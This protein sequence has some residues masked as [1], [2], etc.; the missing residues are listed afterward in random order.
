MS[1]FIYN[2]LI[3]A[4]FF[5]KRN[6]GVKQIHNTLHTVEKKDPQL[7]FWRRIFFF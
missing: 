7:T 1:F 4:R 5:H 2:F 3:Y 6:K